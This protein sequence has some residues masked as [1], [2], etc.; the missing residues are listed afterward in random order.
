MQLN[1]Q[2]QTKKRHNI[3]H[4]IGGLLLILI[5][6]PIAALVA[7]LLIR[8][9]VKSFALGYGLFSFNF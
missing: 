4:M 9:L 7:G 6:G 3:G 5:G 1:S 8:I 2:P